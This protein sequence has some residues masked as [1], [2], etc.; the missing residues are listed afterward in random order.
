MCVER[1]VRALVRLK[2]LLARFPHDVPDDAEHRGQQLIP[3][4]LADDLVET[5]V[6]LGVRFARGDLS[7]LRR[8][9]PAELGELC[10]GDALRGEGRDRRLDESPELDDVGER[11]AARDEAGEGT[12]EII[13]RG[14]ADERAAA[15][16]RLDDA[17]KLERSQG[18]ANGSARDLELFGQLSLGWE[19]IA[20]AKVA[21]LQQTFD[22]LD[23]PLIETDATDRLDDGQGL[24]SPKKPL[25]RWSDQM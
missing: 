6:L 22:L 17:E 4:C 7:L 11:V 10:L 5:R 16:S 15:G 8:E 18:F 9:D 12:R 24:T 25:V 21:L 23:D 20:R 14:L 2:P 3:R 13:R 19:L 1:R